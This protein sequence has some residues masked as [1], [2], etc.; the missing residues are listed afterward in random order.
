MINEFGLSHG[1]L[2]LN[3]ESYLKLARLFEFA[4]LKKCMAWKLRKSSQ[5]EISF[6][7]GICFCSYRGK[8][9]SNSFVLPLWTLETATILYLSAITF[10]SSTSSDVGGIELGS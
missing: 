7:M 5:V 8:A 4:L 10:E 6:F 9:G 3:I 2:G 1:E